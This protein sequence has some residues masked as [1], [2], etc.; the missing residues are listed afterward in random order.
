MLRVSAAFGSTVSAV[1]AITGTRPADESDP[2]AA[3]AHSGARVAA[4]VRDR[5]PLGRSEAVRE[6]TYRFYDDKLF[7]II[8]VYAADKTRTTNKGEFRP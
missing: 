5:A 7:S 3:G 4:P 1:V 8:V 2:P 6:V